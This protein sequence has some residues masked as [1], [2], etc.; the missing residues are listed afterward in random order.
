TRL[1]AGQLTLRRRTH[2]LVSFTRGITLAFAPLAERREITLGF[3][4]GLPALPVAFDAEQLEKV[5]LN[6]LSN[7]LKFTPA[8]GVVEVSVDAESE[9]A[10]IAV[11]DTGIGIAPEDL[12]RVFQRFYQS[13]TSATRRY[14][15]T[16]IGL[17]LARELVGGEIHA[18][19]TPGAGS[20]FT[21]RLPLTDG[22]ERPAREGEEIEREAT[23][24]GAA[25][26]APH[27]VPDVA[28]LA[29]TLPEPEPSPPRQPGADA[30]A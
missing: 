2:D 19:S 21:V 15:G 6:L 26:H 27:A 24:S 10:V 17:A 18:E 7:A 9:A 8:G 29:A 1:Q 14:E 13:D 28:A 20:T 25:S 23:S 16:G 30:V 11:R 12:P 4:T 5:L 3:Q 22:V